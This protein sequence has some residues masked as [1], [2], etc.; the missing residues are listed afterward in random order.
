MNTFE[1]IVA[2]C[3]I[4]IAFTRLFDWVEWQIIKRQEAKDG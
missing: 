4:V 1:S 2:A 3:L